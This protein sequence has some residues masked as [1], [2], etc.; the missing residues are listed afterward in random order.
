M[1]RERQ[2]QEARRAAHS[3]AL[4]ERQTAA[5]AA[6][7]AR[8]LAQKKQLETI[9]S[10]RA[11]YAAQRSQRASAEALAEKDR[12]QAL[13]NRNAQAIEERLQHAQRQAE[14]HRQT[15]AE[16]DAAMAEARKQAAENYE[17]QREA[18]AKKYAEARRQVEQEAEAELERR[19]RAVE[20]CARQEAQRAA[21]AKQLDEQMRVS[22]AADEERAAERAG[23]SSASVSGMRAMR[24]SGG[25]A[26]GAQSCGAGADAEAARRECGGHRASIRARAPSVVGDARG[27]RRA[28]R[29]EARRREMLDA[30]AKRDEARAALSHSCTSRR[31]RTSSARRRGRGPSRMLRCSER[32][33]AQRSH[34]ASKLGREEAE[35]LAMISPVQPRRRSGARRSG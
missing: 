33:S 30:E 17:R 20:E 22:A 21:V 5:Q 13:F 7:E 15:E 14:L 1:E 3:G 34:G 19:R 4:T 2:Q 35:R 18:R 23:C 27:R 24:A 31:R 26:T 25:R 10:R 6:D 9:E 8:K 12:L 16:N 28:A 11:E 29:V 32:R